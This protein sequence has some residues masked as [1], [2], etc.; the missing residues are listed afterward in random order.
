MIRTIL[1]AV[2]TTVFFLQPL[3]AEE[4]EQLSSRYFTIEGAESDRTALFLSQNADAIAESISEQLGFAL[5]G[6][7]RVIIAPDR[8]YFRRVQPAGAQVPE[9]A[10]GVAYPQYNLIVLLKNPGG[11]I[12]KT[13]EHEIC[14]ILLGQAFGPGHVPRWLNE[15]MA[16][17]VAGEWSVQRL[18]TMTMAVLSGNVL[19]M[20]DITHAFPRDEHRAELA[21]C[22]SFYFISFLKSRFGDDE[23]RTFLSI[24]SSCKDF[25]LALWK[26]YYLRWDEI[27]ELWLEYLKLRFSWIPIL[28]STGALWFLASLVFIWGYIHKK[29]KAREKMLPVGAGG[30][31]SRRGRQ[32]NQALSVRHRQPQL[33]MLE[34]RGAFHI[35]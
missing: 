12:L 27:E 7:V 6:R 19:P 34:N 2:C 13:F 21:Y 17:I 11:D 22:Q 15:G 24:Y 5:P 8:E 9:W 16:V 20:D 1:A 26:A 10:V 18:S 31:T 14:H 3:Y 32:R 4:R 23:F 28:F 33:F 30:A 29:R 25:K 35:R